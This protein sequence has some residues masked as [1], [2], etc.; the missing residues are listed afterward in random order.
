MAAAIVKLNPLPDP[1]RP[2]AKDDDLFAVRR[3]R[4]ALWR[5][6]TGRFV[7]RIHVRRLG[8]K[9]GCASINPL[10]DGPHAKFVAVRAHLILGNPASHRN[11]RIAD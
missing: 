10:E 4:F 3:R 11:D 8:L 7:G 2:A 6:E 1:V 5:A 9:F